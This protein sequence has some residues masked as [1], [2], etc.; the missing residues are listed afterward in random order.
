M[1]QPT[2][3]LD[4]D[5]GTANRKVWIINTS[6]YV[7]SEDFRGDKITVPPFGEKK[8]LLGWLAA[9]RFLGQGKPPAR[10]LPDNITLA[11]G[12]PP[13]KALKIVELTSDERLEIEGKTKADVVK[14][15]K[16]EEEMAKLKCAICGGQ[17]LGQ[18]GLKT[19]CTKMHPEFEPVSSEV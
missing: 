6:K 8:V 19:H 2:Q 13:P 5:R 10:Y 11:P 4:I 16:K 14:E 12:S 1:E 3:A 18:K 7:Y 17:F 9:N 15:V